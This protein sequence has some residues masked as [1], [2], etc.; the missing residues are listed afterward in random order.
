MQKRSQ[1]NLK[2]LTRLGTHLFFASALL[3]LPSM[4]NA[5]TIFVN[6]N[7]TADVC[8]ATTCT[9]L[10]AVNDAVAGDEVVIR[11]SVATITLTTPIAVTKGLTIRGEG[12]SVPSI[13]PETFST[14]SS[15]SSP[16]RGLDVDAP[17]AKVRIAGIRFAHFSTAIS[18]TSYLPS[19]LLEIADSVFED[20]RNQQSGGT[21]IRANCPLRVDRSSFNR[22]RYDGQ[23]S[24]QPGAI[25][26]NSYGPTVIT[27]STFRQN[28]A[29]GASGPS[30]EFGHFGEGG[31]IGGY[32]LGL[33]V[34]DSTFVGNR[35]GLGGAINLFGNSSAPIVIRNSTFTGNIALST[36][37]A[38]QAIHAG[39]SVNLVM[40]NVTVTGNQGAANSRAVFSTDG[41]FRYSNS[42]LA[43]NQNA[44]CTASSSEVFSLGGS[45]VDSSCRGGFGDEIAG[46]DPG[47]AT[48]LADNGGATQTLAL[49]ATALA[50]NQGNPQ[51]CEQG[52]QR[53]EYRPATSCDAGAFELLQNPNLALTKTVDRAT[54]SI[55]D[56]LTYTLV[57]TNP[58][59]G[60]ATE[61]V[62]SDVLP[63]ELSFVSATSTTG[64]CGFS[65]GIVS[66]TI[67][68]MAPGASVT[69]T[70]VTTV[71]SA[72]VVDNLAII[73][74]KE[75]D[76][77]IANNSGGA[78]TNIAPPGAPICPDANVAAVVPSF[79]QGGAFTGCQSVAVNDLG[80]WAIAL[81][82]LV[83]SARNQR[84]RRQ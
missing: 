29:L 56:T 17:A 20:N 7:G 11:E 66:C 24:G 68:T 16:E 80:A 44:S 75:G 27:R 40:N 35:A 51:T 50:K 2:Q 73:Q 1:P 48:T 42:I 63:G 3:G 19:S 36:L 25:S 49:L 58:G 43:N 78:R 32:T 33:F 84:P 30:G 6:S 39:S 55:G 82:V 47:V 52:D 4:A 18:E 22:N 45:V 65:G 71:T 61:V 34:K 5:A 76:E 14:A 41:G 23:S 53:G 64:T 15:F 69:I 72:G 67:G 59:A 70:I 54:G 46:V 12:P 26:T 13:Q 8:D 74:S 79:F 60:P 62:V 38:G 21:A 81:L 37:N 83:R 31:A 28:E 9:L 57:A 77:D 10:G